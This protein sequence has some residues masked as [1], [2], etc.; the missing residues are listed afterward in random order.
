MKPEQAP[1]T[2]VASTSS[3]RPSMPQSSVAIP[4]VALSAVNVQTIT[5]SISLAERP[6]SS[7]AL[8][9]A[10]QAISA[11]LSSSANHLL[12]MPLFSLIHS[13][14]VSIILARSSFRTFLLP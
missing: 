13:S 1:F 6:D 3:L 4:G 7:I 10:S 8:I 12:S 14:L 5:A 11:L 2:S 9:D